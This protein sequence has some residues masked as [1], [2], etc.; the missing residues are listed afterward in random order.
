MTPGAILLHQ[1]GK[2]IGV[3]SDDGEVLHTHN[4]DL[5]AD[6]ARNFHPCAEEDVPE[7]LSGLLASARRRAVVKAGS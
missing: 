7:K 2:A 1:R 3:V 4:M 5:S 6:Q